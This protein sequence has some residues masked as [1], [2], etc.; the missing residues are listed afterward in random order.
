MMTG[1]GAVKSVWQKLSA[2]LDSLSGWSVAGKIRSVNWTG[3]NKTSVRIHD[4][5]IL[6]KAT[7]FVSR[8]LYCSPNVTSLKRSYAMRNINKELCCGIVQ[9]NNLNIR[10]VMTPVGQQPAKN[11]NIDYLQSGHSGG[12]WEQ[13]DDVVPPCITVLAVPCADPIRLHK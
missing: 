9:S 8:V 3:T 4:I 7:L 10:Q 1:F 6:R 2:C 11:P 5:S 13:I 12:K